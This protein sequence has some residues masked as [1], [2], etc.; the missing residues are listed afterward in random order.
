M[1]KKDFASVIPMSHFLVNDMG[2]RCVAKQ[3]TKC[4]MGVVSKYTI[5]GVTHF[6]NGPFC[7][8]KY[9]HSSC[10]FLL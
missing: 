1:Y 7:K 9:I 6:M 3:M 5:F 2:E 8:D 10:Y 4:D